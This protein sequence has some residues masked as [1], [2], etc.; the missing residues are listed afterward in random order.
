MSRGAGMTTPISLGGADEH[1]AAAISAIL[2]DLLPT[3]DYSYRERL[4]LPPLPPDVEVVPATALREADFLIATIQRAA[5]PWQAPNLRVATA[6]WNKHFN[7]AVLS[8]PLA[9]MTL[10]G[11]GL[12][13]SLDNSCLILRDG[14]PKALLPVS[15]ASAVVHTPRLPDGWHGALAERTIDDLSAFRRHVL[16][17][18]LNQHLA[19]MIE[20]LHVVTRLSPKIMW[21]NAGNLCAHLYETLA[22]HPRGATAADDRAFVLD[23]PYSE[24]LARPN[25][26][27]QSVQ[28]LPLAEPDLPPTV[29]VRRTCC[30]RWRLPD[31][32]FCYVCPCLTHDERLALMRQMQ[33]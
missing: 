13:A 21:G 2:H 16:T 30:L 22:E 31:G 1:G 11:L 12:D 3:L 26:L 8:G 29:R 7:A 18:L 25:P 24:V 6:L 5:E 4:A 27:Y 33:R 10:V 28:S 14:L 32:L 19:P 9:A 23:A 15:L 17:R 20:R